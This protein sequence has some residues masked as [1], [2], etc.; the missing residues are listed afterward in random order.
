MPSG[1]TFS[2]APSG[3]PKSTFRPD[4]QGL[5]AIAVLAVISDHL[6]HRP[7]GGFAGV[8]VFFVI[9][10]FL[11]TSLL[12][13]EHEKTGRISFVGF[14]RRR[15]KRILPAALVVILATL[16]AAFFFF[17]GTRLTQTVFDSLW[18]ALFSANWA[19]A[20]Q[21]T[22]YFGSTQAVSPLQH[23]WSLAVEEQFYLVWPWLMLLIIAVVAMVKGTAKHAQRTILIAIVI[24]SVTSFV[25]SLWESSAS[26]TW[27]YFSTLSRAWELGVGATLAAAASLFA[28]T[29]GA[30][31]TVMSWVGLLG[32]VASLLLVSDESSF[33]APW[34]ALPVLATAMVIAAGIGETPKHVYVLD[35]RVASY[36]GDI[37]YSLYLWH[38]PIIVFAGVL[39]GGSRLSYYVAV[40]F[41]TATLS[42]VSYHFIEDPVRRSNLFESKKG[43]A[44]Q[45]SRNKPISF[46]LKLVAI[47]ATIVA[48]AGV[49]VVPVV[50]ERPAAAPGVVSASCS[51]DSQ[52]TSTALLEDLCNEIKVSLAATEWPD[53]TPTM[54]D[55]LAHDPGKIETDCH[56]I[57]R[58]KDTEK[59]VWGNPQG[60]FEIVL[61]GDSTSRA[62]ARTF[63][64]IA[65][66]NPDVRVTLWTFTGCR[67]NSVASK[68]NDPYSARICPDRV[69]AAIDYI[70][71]R[72]PDLVVITNE[73]GA[74][75][76]ANG[77]KLTDEVW[78]AG[79]DDVVSQI[80]DSATHIVFLAATPLG[81]NPGECYTPLS[82][83]Q[84]CVSKVLSSSVRESRMAIDKDLASE[85][86]GV[87]IDST[88][89]MCLDD[90]CP[91]VI[92]NIPARFDSVHLS[93]ALASHLSPLI[94]ELLVE[95]GVFTK[96]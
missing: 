50:L 92:A 67:F 44:Q 16:V 58:P 68:G 93:A 95:S 8:D 38:W 33:P 25:W 61:V 64:D 72:Q 60:D 17:N 11:I 12:L 56:T 57:H 55:V 6:F 26:P 31:R 96:S 20:V 47:G 10:G 66:R 5:R 62:Y 91:A 30:L 79:L 34:A 15:A 48:L 71:E 18:A 74:R 14:Y 19:F 27:A 75:V 2:D 53:M 29:P 9:S 76:Q 13:R 24:L 89:F 32:I 42:V 86:G 37:S 94:E 39:Y 82:S 7:S 59:C 70:Q 46:R 83:P 41:A 35:N 84:D 40:V 49:V 36:I 88:G 45:S 85:V 52:T 54:D 90:L 77:D 78:R 22:D 63:V 21:G 28:R 87:F 23:Y 81:A 80:K 69:V 65:S 51:S 73:Y 1:A 43:R 3:T 4:V